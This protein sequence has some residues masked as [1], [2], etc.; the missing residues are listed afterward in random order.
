MTPTTAIRRT[1]RSGRLQ[2]RLEWRP[3]GRLHP[4]SGD[5]REHAVRRA[6]P[7]E[8]RPQPAH[9]RHG[10]PRPAR[11]PQ[12][13]DI[14]AAFRPP[15]PDVRAQRPPGACRSTCSWF[16]SGRPGAPSKRPSS[17]RMPTSR[18]RGRPPT[19]GRA[20]CRPDYAWTDL[21]YLLHKHH[22]SWG[23]YINKGTEPDCETGEN[24]RACPRQDPRTPGIW[25]PLPYF[26]TVREVASSATSVTPALL[27]GRRKGGLP[28]VSWVIPSG[29]V[30]EH[31]TVLE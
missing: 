9:R 12:L 29:R 14:C 13:L 30:S 21:T 5:L 20:V 27:C 23:Y 2:D 8:L 11:D 7:R 15:G 1:A 24:A 28:A 4:S 6:G 26:D 25:N 16:R 19:S 22:V 3:H 18:P 31:P 10:L 17:C